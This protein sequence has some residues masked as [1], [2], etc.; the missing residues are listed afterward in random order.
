MAREIE[1]EAK[2]LL[3]KEEL[4]QLQDTFSI[5]DSQFISQT[6]HYFDTL[7]FNLKERKA[8]LRIREKNSEFMITLKQPNRVGLMETNQSVSKEEAEQM[9]R[10]GQLPDGEVKEDI[11]TLKVPIGQFAYLGSLTTSRAEITVNEQIV[12]LDISQYLDTSDYEL[13]VEGTSVEAVNSLFNSLL[14]QHNIPKRPT[15]N[16]IIRFFERKQKLQGS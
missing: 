6:N 5:N 7:G 2:N 12:V 3:T 4:Q 10:T 11:E 14:Q 1:I 16:K 9:I 15:K 13:E 8:A